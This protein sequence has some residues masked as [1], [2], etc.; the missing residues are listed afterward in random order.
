MGV[1]DL[2]ESGWRRGRLGEGM[3]RKMKKECKRMVHQKEGRY[4]WS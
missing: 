4:W 1:L 2:R 3:N